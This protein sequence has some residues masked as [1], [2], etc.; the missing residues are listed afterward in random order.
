MIRMAEAGFPTT[1]EDG[2]RWGCQHLGVFEPLP[3]GAP[4]TGDGA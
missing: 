2:G 4:A 1:V 3:P